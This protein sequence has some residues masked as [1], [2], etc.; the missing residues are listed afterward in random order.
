MAGRGRWRGAPKRREKRWRRRRRLS[1]RRR[2]SGQAEAGESEFASARRA[3]RTAQSGTHTIR[4]ATTSHCRAE[5]CRYRA[6]RD[7]A[8]AILHEDLGDVALL[9]RFPP[10]CR[11]VRL[12]VAQ[13]IT[14]RDLVSRSDHP[15]GCT[16]IGQDREGDRCAQRLPKNT[17]RYSPLSW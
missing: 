2:P 7:V 11:L 13:M 14:R 3:V 15:L 9:L 16:W 10:D 4:Y 6:D 8:G 12:D 5:V 17:H 1:R